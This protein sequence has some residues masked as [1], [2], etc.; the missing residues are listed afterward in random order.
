[1]P[2]SRLSSFRWRGAFNADGVIELQLIETRDLGT[3]K[4]AALDNGDP[5]AIRAV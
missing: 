2:F 3:V 1:V 5:S 4:R